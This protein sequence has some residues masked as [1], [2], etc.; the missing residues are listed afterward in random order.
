MK[1][2]VSH[3][4]LPDRTVVSDDA[5][6]RNVDLSEPIQL[7]FVDGKVTV[8]IFKQLY[9]AGMDAHFVVKNL[10]QFIFKMRLFRNLEIKVVDGESPTRDREPPKEIVDAFG[11]KNAPAAESQLDRMIERYIQIERKLRKRDVDD[12]SIARGV[13]L[14]FRPR[15]FEAI[16]SSLE[17]SELYKSKATI[18]HKIFGLLKGGK[19]TIHEIETVNGAVESVHRTL[20]SM[21][22]SGIVVKKGEYFLLSEI[23][24]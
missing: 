16:R 14:S 21:V 9:L 23:F 20:K 12:G 13:E 18:S 6:E 10:E 17:N 19:K 15:I 11:A 4:I 5:K 7:V 3:T 24:C 2:F 22:Y 8:R 1:I